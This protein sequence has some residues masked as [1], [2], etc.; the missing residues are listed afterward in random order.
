[1][2][3]GSRGCQLVCLDLMAKSE[4]PKA[5]LP[6]AGKSCS[7]I[8]PIARQ[9]PQLLVGRC[10]CLLHACHRPFVA[11]RCRNSASLLTPTH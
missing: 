5:V 7:F 11:H 4:A 2:L 8:A 6:G 10:L 3:Q 9:A 1:M